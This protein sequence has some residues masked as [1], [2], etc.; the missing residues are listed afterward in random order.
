MRTLVAAVTVVAAL[1]GAPPA[2]ADDPTPPPTP[3]QIQGPDGPVLPGN[4]VLPPV[5]ARAMQACGYSLDPGTMTWR[6]K[7]GG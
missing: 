2:H 4:Q 7:V 1:V 6:P 5:C 3:Y